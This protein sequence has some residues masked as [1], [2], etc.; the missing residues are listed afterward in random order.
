MQMIDQRRAVQARKDR[1]ED[2]NGKRAALIAVAFFLIAQ[3]V[4]YTI[5]TGGVL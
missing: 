4:V 2:R 1:E 5:E 3:T